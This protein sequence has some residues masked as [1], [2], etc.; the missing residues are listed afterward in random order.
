MNTELTTAEKTILEGWSNARAERELANEANG[1]RDREHIRLGTQHYAMQW[2]HNA[3]DANTGRRCADYFW[4]ASRKQRDAW[5]EDGA[6]Y[7]G[8]GYREPVPASDSELR[9]L[10]RLEL[11][12]EE[13]GL[14]IEA[15]N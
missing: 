11:A 9:A 1:E 6:P 3:V 7:R 12:R 5:V 13:R 14:W 10:Q 8:R 2:R 15:M 4:F